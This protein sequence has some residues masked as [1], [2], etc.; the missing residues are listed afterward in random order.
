MAEH[1]YLSEEALAKLINAFSGT[2]VQSKWDPQQ[3]QQL[4]DRKFK[5]LKRNRISYDRDIISKQYQQKDQQ[6]SSKTSHRELKFMEINSNQSFFMI[7]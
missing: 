5:P 3:L 4:V 1:L 6:G 7:S 2:G